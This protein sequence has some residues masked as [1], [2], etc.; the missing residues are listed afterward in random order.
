L[1]L[2]SCSHS[3]QHAVVLLAYL[4][5]WGCRVD[6]ITLIVTALVAGA[7]LGMKDTASSAVK[8]AYAGL[9]AL[10]GKRL[11]G[12]PD[13]ELVL[14]RHAA[15]PEIWRAPLMEELRQVEADHDADLVS[16][17]ETLMRLVDS[18]GG[19]AGKYSISVRGA[20]GVQIGDSNEQRNVFH[21]LP[22]GLRPEDMTG[23]S[24][25]VEDDGHESRG[26]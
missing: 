19:Q 5:A 7:A 9:K 3:A 18:A 22:G 23:R 2:T 1:R 10:A 13:G 4:R 14:A 20:Q 11:A 15:A 24:G 17:A 25:P 8:D 12:R 6:P 16:A 26:R 21:A